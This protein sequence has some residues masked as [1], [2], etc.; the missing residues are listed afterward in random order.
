VLI[1]PAIKKTLSAET[2]HYLFLKKKR[3]AKNRFILDEVPG[4]KPDF[5]H[6]FVLSPMVQNEM[7]ES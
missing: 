4:F 5:A 6:V 7:F 2:P 3:P 1:H